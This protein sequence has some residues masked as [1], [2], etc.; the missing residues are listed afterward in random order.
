MIPALEVQA[1]TGE[2]W[3]AQSSSALF[4]KEGSIFLQSSWE[5][6]LVNAVEKVLIIYNICIY[7][8][9]TNTFQQRR[10][11]ANTDFWK[12]NHPLV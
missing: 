11:E 4:Y 1:L 8:L 6:S 10:M 2:L 9:W 3:N 5:M 12:Q 7:G